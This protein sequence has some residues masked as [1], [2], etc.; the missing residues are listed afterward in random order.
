MACDCPKKPKKKKQTPPTKGRKAKAEDSESESDAES[1]H[2]ASA[3]IKWDKNLFWQMVAV[4]PEEDRV[5]AVRRAA[6]TEGEEGF[7]KGANPLIWARAL[8]I[9]SVFKCKYKS[10]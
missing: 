1:V 7:L 6:A 2:G 4:A 5:E 9:K 10:L 3:T 8:G